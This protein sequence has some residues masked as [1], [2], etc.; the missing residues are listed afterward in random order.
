MKSPKLLDAKA[1]CTQ[2]SAEFLINCE[3]L[4]LAINGKDIWWQN[5]IWLVILLIF[6]I[7]F[8][9]FFLLKDYRHK[10]LIDLQQHMWLKK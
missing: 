4:Y 6:A 9:L 2:V 5:E 1:S 7:S 3:N 8:I 10:M